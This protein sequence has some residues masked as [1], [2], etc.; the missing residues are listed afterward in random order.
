LKCTGIA[1][2]WFAGRAIEAPIADV[3]RAS[4]RKGNG[5]QLTGSADYRTVIRE[6]DSHKVKMQAEDFE[7]LGAI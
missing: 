6:N 5:S 3:L 1:A 7:I 2:G 4:Q